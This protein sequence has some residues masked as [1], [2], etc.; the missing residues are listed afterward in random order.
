MWTEWHDAWRPRTRHAAAFDDDR[1]RLVVFGGLVDS[2]PSDETWEWDVAAGDSGWSRIVSSGAV[3]PPRSDPMMVYDAPR[4][5]MILFGGRGADRLPLGD[6][7]EY[8]GN[9]WI[10]ISPATSPS[11]RRSAGMVFDSARARVV[12]VGGNSSLIAVGTYP[13]ETWEYDGSTWIDRTAESATK[14]SGRGEASAAWDSVRQRV[15]LFGGFNNSGTPL[16]DTWEYAN[17][18][19]SPG[20]TGPAG[21]YGAQMAYSSTNRV[22]LYGGK[23][24]AGSA[25]DTWEYDGVTW[26]LKAPA[27]LVPPGR[28]FGTASRLGSGAIAL[29]G[30]IDESP[31]EDVWAYDTA[32]AWKAHPVQLSAPPRCCATMTY[33]PSS[34]QAIVL[35]GYVVNSTFDDSWGFDGTRWQ[36]YPSVPNTLRR[37]TFAA[38]YDESRSRVVAFGGV[39]LA[40]QQADDTLERDPATGLFSAVAP[41]VRPP[42]QRGGAMVYDPALGALVLF[43]GSIGTTNTNSVESNATWKFDG[44]TWEQLAAAPAPP[45]S[46]GPALAWDP[47]GN[48][49]IA[50]SGSETWQLV[51]GVWSRLD[52]ATNPSSRTGAAMAFNPE[53]RRMWMYGG[54]QGA[55]LYTDLWEL[56]DTGWHELAQSGEGPSPRGDFKLVRF[57]PLRSFLLFGGSAASTPSGETWFLQFRSATPDE[58]CSNGV[59]DDGDRHVDADDSDCT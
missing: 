25:S 43:G 11:P 56:D 27:P 18:T 41:T 38:A 59:D 52:L 24:L 31:R 42:K 21:R 10:Q 51:D 13:A 34:Q 19:W 45:A 58:D 35:G 54:G 14:P 32:G 40:G 26:M 23:T 12:L 50:F 39:A 20:P 36:R 49:L 1:G 16:A 47:V 37:H 15:V 55:A 48:R 22:V 44:S 30:G 2:S 3:P 6:T 53:R 28:A 4:E 8:D 57:P 7:W 9:Q 17:G 5:R 33:D 46:G 29:V